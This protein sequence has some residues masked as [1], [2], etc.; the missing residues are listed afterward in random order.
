MLPFVVILEQLLTVSQF[1]KN[2]FNVA[3]LGLIWK[4]FGAIL[5]AL[6]SSHDFGRGF[7]WHSSHVLFRKVV[8]SVTTFVNRLLSGIHLVLFWSLF[9]IPWASSNEDLVA[10]IWGNPGEHSGERSGERSGEQ[11]RRTI[12]E[13]SQESNLGLLWVSLG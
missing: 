6:W 3:A 10:W 7:L 11:A 5:A 1:F 2:E 8:A 12:L 13:S 4:P 9:G